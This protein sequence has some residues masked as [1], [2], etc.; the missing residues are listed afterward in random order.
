MQFEHLVQVNDPNHP[1]ITPL[2]RQQVWLGL[3]VKVYRPEKFSLG[4]VDSDVS[5]PNQIDGKTVV[6][7]ELN[8][9]SFVVNDSVTMHEENSIVTEVEASEHHGHCQMTVS[10]EEPVKNE[11]WLR[12]TY[13]IDKPIAGTDAKLEEDQVQEARKQA[14]AAADID[15]VKMIR[16]IAAMNPDFDQSSN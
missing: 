10:I 13:S 14:Y 9:G 4:L 7:R 8:Y 11:L 2:S 12:F 6:K 3:V 1:L 16:A 15:T 5:Q